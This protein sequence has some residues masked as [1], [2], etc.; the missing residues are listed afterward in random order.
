MEEMVKISD[1]FLIRTDFFLK[2]PGFYYL[3]W[4]SFYLKWPGFFL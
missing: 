3:K 4:P 1:Y 2:W